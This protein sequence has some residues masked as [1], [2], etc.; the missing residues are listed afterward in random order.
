MQVAGGSDRAL[1]FRW[2][3]CLSRLLGGTDLNIT[4]DLRQ[5]DNVDVRNRG[6]P[7]RP[8]PPR[9][10]L[11]PAEKTALRT[12]TAFAKAMGSP[13][14][15]ADGVI[16]VAVHPPS[17]KILPP[18]V[19][20]VGKSTAVSTRLDLTAS[21]GIA[22]SA[23]T[24]IGFTSGA[25]IYGSTTG[26]VGLYTTVGGGLFLGAGAG[27][28]VSVS[29]IFGTPA[30]FAGVFIGVGISV[31][32]PPPAIVSAGAILLF[33][34]VGTGFVLMGWEIP[35]MVGPQWPPLAFS[36]TATNTAT[37]PVLKF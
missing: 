16:D 22:G 27:A 13:I 11:A 7:L 29:L 32:C 35:F 17:I 36:L 30:D 23:F 3:G 8:G 4:A 1:G 28:G 14:G 2:S 10:P 34:P 12:G 31:A 26:E 21:Y 20:A 37:L 9:R 33:S 15:Q 5:L 19:T 18:K 6:V 24:G 25:G